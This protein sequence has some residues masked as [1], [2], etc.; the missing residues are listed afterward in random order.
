[1]IVFFDIDGTLWD[2]QRNIPESTI[3]AIR[4]LRNNGHKAF[5]CSGRARANINDERLFDIGFDGVIAACGNHVEYEGQ[6]VYQKLLSDEEVR[7]IINVTN[8]CRLPIVMEGPST[9]LISEKGFENDPYVDYLYQRLGELALPVSAYKTEMSFNKF[10]AGI[11]EYSDYET[12]KKELE[13][14]MDSLEHN[15]TVVEFV[16]KGTSKATGIIELCKYLNVDISDTFAIGDSI[17]DVDMLKA[18]GHGIA[19]GNGTQP[20]FEAAEYIT[21]SLHEDGIKNALTHYELI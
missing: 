6:V 2:G 10:S 14:F 5:I 4:K 20:A 12:V 8:E 13:P 11:M 19:M 15:A 9:H 3:T 7:K 1:M 17:N 16:P 18:V 21:T